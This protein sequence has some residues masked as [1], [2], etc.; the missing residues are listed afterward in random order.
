MYLFIFFFCLSGILDSHKHLL[1][2]ILAPGSADIDCQRDV[3]FLLFISSFQ[4]DA[5]ECKSAFSPCRVG[6]W[7]GWYSEWWRGQWR[8][9]WGVVGAD[10]S[11]GGKELQGRWGDKACREGVVCWTVLFPLC[12]VFSWKMCVFD[13]WGLFR[14]THSWPS[15]QPP[16]WHSCTASVS[17]DKH[18]LDEWWGVLICVCVSENKAKKI[19][20]NY[21]TVYLCGKNKK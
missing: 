21:N 20:K 5:A 2:V 6:W 8:W 16:S 11:D 3:S 9:W 15:D 1:T 10:G 18:R 7:V 14:R 17:K 13:C 12:C 19:K 4:R